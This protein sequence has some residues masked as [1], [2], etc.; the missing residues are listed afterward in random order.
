MQASRASEA[1]PHLPSQPPLICELDGV[2]PLITDPYP[3]QPELTEAVE[4][5]LRLQCCLNWDELTK[6]RTKDCITG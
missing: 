5:L 1:S 4:Q 2:A 6:Q 3:R